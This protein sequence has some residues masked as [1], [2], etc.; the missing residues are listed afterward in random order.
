MRELSPKQLAAIHTSIDLGRT[1]QRDC[2]EIMELYRDNFSLAQIVE[3]LEIQSRYHVGS[4]VASMGVYKALLGHEGGFRSVAYRGLIPE[5][6]MRDLGETHMH[7]SGS[8]YGH[9]GGT[10]AYEKKGGCHGINPKTGERYCEEGAKKGG[11]L[12]G[13]KGGQKGGRQRTIQKGQTPWITTEDIEAQGLE[14][15]VSE[16]EYANFLSQQQKYRIRSNVACKKIAE[17]LN[18]IYHHNMPIRN[19]D[20]VRHQLYKKYRRL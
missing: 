10:R 20:A 11:S 7:I 19:P 5:E 13:I 16:I 14:H 1:L 17:E 15:T 2:P 18:R 8:L 6:E 12:G 3:K 4:S 9:R